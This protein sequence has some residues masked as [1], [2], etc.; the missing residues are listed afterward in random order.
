MFRVFR[1]SV[2]WEEFW[3]VGIGF[4]CMGWSFLFWVEEWD[5]DSF[6]LGSFLGIRGSWEDVI[7]F[8]TK[9]LGIIDGSG[10]EGEVNRIEV[11][12]W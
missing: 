4:R 10:E 9:G 6:D 11:I 1:V 7:L 12:F 8:D 5:G 2:E 3:R